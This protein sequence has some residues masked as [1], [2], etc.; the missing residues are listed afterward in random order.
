[1]TRIAALADLHVDATDAHPYRDLFTEISG[2][3]DALALC[4][5]L[6]NRGKIAEAEILAE[7]LHACRIPMVGVLGN[8]DFDGG[9][10]DAI[11][12]ILKQGGLRLLG[13]QTC[14]IHGIGFA[15]VK[16]FAGG[17]GRYMLSAFG[18]DAIKRFVAE[19]IN[20][21]TQL[22]TALHSLST[23]RTVILLHYAPITD[24]VQGEPIEILPF[25]GSSR[26]AEA[27]DRFNVDAVFH[28]HA[29]HG[30]YA[31]KT[32]KGVPVYNCAKPVSKPDGRA[33]ALIEL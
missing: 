9:E 7:D 25:L 23:D 30:S 2:E 19:V 1:M 6:T 24:T 5:D 21:T 3:A 33:Y 12:R 4:G 10:V 16:G 31:G 27:I 11:E 15:G 13:N 32:P 29:H 8:H 26:L 18:E 28:G 17:F 20:E 14:D 22:E